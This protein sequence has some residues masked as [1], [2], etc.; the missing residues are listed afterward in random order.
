M[1]RVTE[2]WKDFLFELD[3]VCEAALDQ[4]RPADRDL[5]LLIKRLVEELR[6]EQAITAFDAGVTASHDNGVEHY[7]I[8]EFHYFHL[9]GEEKPPNRK[10]QIAAAKAI[11][12]GLEIL[13]KFPEWLRKRLNVLNDVL[14]L[15]M[16]R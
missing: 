11:E 5:V 7:L 16:R 15:V 9:L 6:S 2:V 8:E 10:E 3:T 12:E 1:N 13:F 14:A 4:T